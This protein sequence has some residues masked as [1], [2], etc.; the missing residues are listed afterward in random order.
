MKKLQATFA[1]TQD[2]ITDFEVFRLPYNQMGG[3]FQFRRQSL[4]DCV[5]PIRAE[6]STPA[7]A[8]VSSPPASVL[9]SSPQF[10]QSIKSTFCLS[11]THCI[12]IT[13]QL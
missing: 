3:V 13:H 4:A 5:R 11:S 6:E 9:Q 7:S 8:R 1:S 10:V 12:L 2:V